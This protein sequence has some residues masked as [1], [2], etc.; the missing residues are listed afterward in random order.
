MKRILTI[1]ICMLGLIFQS[2]AQ[3]DLLITPRRVVFEG[4][5]QKEE[6]NLVNIGK[7]TAI[8]FISFIQYQMKEDGSFVS[9]ETPGPGQMFADPF[10]R[11]FP[12]KVTLAPGEPQVIMLQ[13]KRKP[14]MLAGEYRSHLYFRSENKSEPL[15]MDDK[16]QDTTLLAVKL[17]PIYGMSIPVIIHSGDAKATST[18][19]DLKLEIKRDTIQSLKLTINRTGNISLYGDIVIECTPTVGKTFEIGKVRGVGVYTDI[20]K[21]NVVVRLNNTTASALQNGKLKVKYVTNQENTKPVVIAEGE[22]D[23]K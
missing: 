22:L 5:K 8:Y 12:R 14:D 17:I 4:T 20:T 18:L 2:L 21:R 3:G 1:L 10:L 16:P 7:D 6:L 19:S 23:I 13:C 15:G 9:V 11:I